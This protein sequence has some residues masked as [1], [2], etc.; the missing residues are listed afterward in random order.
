MDARVCSKVIVAVPKVVVAGGLLHGAILPSGGTR[1]WTT[2]D[3]IASRSR[4]RYAPRV[5]RFRRFL[6]VALR[7]TFAM[8]FMAL[9]LAI[10]FG[11]AGIVALWAHPP[12]TSARAELTWQGDTKLGDVLDGFQTSLLSIAAHTDRLVLLARFTQGSAHCFGAR[13]VETEQV[14]LV[15]GHIDIIMV[16]DVGC[17]DATGKRNARAHLARAVVAR[18]QFVVAGRS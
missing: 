5:I 6:G 10:A 14:A 16:V 15:V 7:V 9:L 3:G 2:W 8:V 17:C 13:E 12:G 1:R 11:S 4:S 18:S